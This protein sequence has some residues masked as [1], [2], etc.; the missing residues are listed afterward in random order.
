MPDFFWQGRQDSNSR[1]LVL[2]TSALPTELRPFVLDNYNIKPCYNGIVKA[3]DDKRPSQEDIV[4][5]LHD[6]AVKNPIRIR[7]KDDCSN[8]PIHSTSKKKKVIIVLAIIMATLIVAG[9]VVALLILV[10]NAKKDGEKPQ[11][12][13]LVRYDGV[14]DYLVGR[15]ESSAE[16]GSCF[17]FLDGGEAHWYLDCADSSENYSYGRIDVENGI[18]RGKEA[19]GATSMTLGS[20]NK[21]FLIEDEITEDDVYY[22]RI[23]ITSNVRNGINIT[24][25]LGDEVKILFVRHGASKKA[26]GYQ[27]NTGDIYQLEQKK[28]PEP[29]VLPTLSNSQN[30]L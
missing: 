24:K 5:E 15:W 2:E 3:S 22:V 4:A 12:E 11:E 29:S 19:L 1:H 6:V 28:A 23:Q 16:N 13:E 14:Y 10:G 8:A 20:V 25:P 17:D 26:Y 27:I 21:I 18:K 9:G 7:R 30:V